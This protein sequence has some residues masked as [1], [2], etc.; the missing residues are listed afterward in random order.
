MTKC[1]LLASAFATSFLLSSAF[2][3]APC[4][5]TNIGGPLGLTD[6]S[7]AAGLPLGFNFTFPD[8]TVT[9]SIDVDSN[10]R[11]LLPGG[12]T[13]DL[14]E[15]VAELLA[16]SSS[17]CPLWDDLNP[18]GT[19]ADDVY[20]NALPG[21]A[22][23][24][25]N[26]IVVYGTSAPF[27][28]QCTLWADGRITFTYD[29]RTPTGN[30]AIVGTS[31]GNGA[32][33]PGAIDYSTR[34]FPASAFTVYEQFT[35]AF[36]LN[37]QA[38][39]FLPTGTAYV[40]ISPTGC[41]TA[42]PIGNGC[43]G[44]SPATFYEIFDGTST[45]N[46][47]SNSAGLTAN[48]IG[49]GYAVTQGTGP[50]VTPSGA[51]LSLTDD[52]TVQVMLPWTM[53]TQNGGTTDVWICSNGWV[54]LE[55]TTAADLGE[56][57][58]ALISGPTRIACVWDDLNPASGGAVYAEQDPA[59]PGLFHI[60]WDQVPEFALGGSN[61]FQ[62]TLDASG[63]WQLKFG[64]MSLSD[65]MSG[66]SLG[67]G[68][69]DAGASDL[70]AITGAILVGDDR[71]NLALAAVARPLIGQ[72]ASLETR[73]IPTG[74]IS[75]FLLYGTVAIPLPG[76]DLGAI[77]APGCSIYHSGD[78]VVPFAVA[79]PTAQHSLRVPNNPSLAGAHLYS[80]SVVFA[81]GV[82]TLGAITSNAVDWL[83][84]TR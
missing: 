79:N 65:G 21:K 11:I 52:Q 46:D 55:A 60:T 30:D 48:W 45:I 1:T 12:D 22:V 3:Q 9:S 31:A 49:I 8:G 61:T 32:A 70:T 54:A 57:V 47:L 24:T 33:D 84:E 82:N 6:D 27:T 40:V 59:N 62:L 69:T 38:V 63:G 67:N 7:I 42:T 83:I 34:P 26:D 17:I 58:A 29:S 77:G 68:A 10:G 80:Q 2:A 16:E 78:V 14:S 15:S 35:T 64:A 56:S 39:E 50:F 76:I 44:G 37:D 36:D 75:G 28:F 5:E 73:A 51:P 66:Y 71:P 18:N 41:A 23:I 13:T 53:P 25:W 72:T 20:F 74:S 43:G 19:N 4:F 81:P